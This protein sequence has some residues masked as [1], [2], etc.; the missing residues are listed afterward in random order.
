ML[1]TPIS[2]RLLCETAAR[3]TYIYCDLKLVRAFPVWNNLSRDISV[4]ANVT[5]LLL[6][7]MKNVNVSR[8]NRIGRQLQPVELAAGEL[9]VNWQTTSAWLQLSDS[10][11]W[12]RFN[13]TGNNSNLW[14]HGREKIVLS[15]CSFLFYFTLLFFCANNHLTNVTAV[16]EGDPFLCH[17]LWH[18]SSTNRSLILISVAVTLPNEKVIRLKCANI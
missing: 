6:V 5:V 17:G 7:L 11:E 2:T 9:A 1:F 18:I 4:I 14:L 13:R 12:A 10:Q 8:L 15:F 16:E 3:T